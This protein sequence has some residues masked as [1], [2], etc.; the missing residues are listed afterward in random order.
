MVGNQLAADGGGHRDALRQGASA[1]VG[2][3]ADHRRRGDADFFGKASSHSLWT[4]VGAEFGLAIASDVVG[5]GVA[6]A[7]SVLV[8]ASQ[9]DLAAF[10]DPMFYDKLE[11]A[12]RQSTGRIALVSSL[13]GICQDLV[14]LASL[15]GALIL[16]SLW[17][18]A[19]RAGPPVGC[20]QP[21][22][23]GSQNLRTGTIPRRPLPAHFRPRLRREQ[24]AGLSPH[25]PRRVVQSDRNRRILRRLGVHSAADDRRRDP[26]REFD[27]PGRFLLPV[28]KPDREHPFRVHEH[29]GACSSSSK[30]SPPSDRARKPCPRRPI[31]A[32]FEFRN[33]SFAYP[34]STRLIVQNISFRLKSREKIGPHRR[35]W[36]QQDHP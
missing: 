22:R 13:L 34:G 4:L 1:C 28:E 29:L 2:L 32:G 11:R 36:D 33:V 9:L 18:A 21:E 23:Q 16:F 19:P 20:K 14:T 24:D 30:W 25:Q 5:R 8:T 35:E 12:R 3:E 27:I 10:E 31:R 7:Y 15:S 6:L 26:S 17:L